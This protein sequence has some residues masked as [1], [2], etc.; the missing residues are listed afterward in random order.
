MFLRVSVTASNN[1][2]IS[3]FDYISTNAVKDFYVATPIPVAWRSK[4][5]FYSGIVPGIAGSNPDERKGIWTSVC[6]ALCS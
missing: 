5:A 6:C 1:L 4:L 2:D 3:A